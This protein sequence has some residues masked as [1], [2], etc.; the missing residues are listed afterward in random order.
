MLQGVAVG[1]SQ[2]LARPRG[3]MTSPEGGGRGERLLRRDIKVKMKAKSCWDSPGGGRAG[4]GLSK[5]SHCFFL[6]TPGQTVLPDAHAGPADLRQWGAG[7][8]AGL[9]FPPWGQSEAR[10]MASPPSPAQHGCHYLRASWC[11]SWEIPSSPRQGRGMAL[12]SMCPQ[13][14][15]ARER[16]GEEVPQVAGPRWEVPSLDDGGCS[17]GLPS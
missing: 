14:P 11:V 10:W 12:G 13:H 1:T 16:G 9:L 8:H 6:N 2:G 3:Q 17:P 4:G 5:A 15:T 7:P